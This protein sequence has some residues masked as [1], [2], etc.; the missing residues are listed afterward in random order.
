MDRPR[1]VGGDSSTLE[2]VSRQQDAFDVGNVTG[3]AGLPVG[4]PRRV[5]TRSCRLGD[6]IVVIVAYGSLVGEVTDAALVAVVEVVE[7]IESAI[8]DNGV[9]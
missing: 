2:V 8:G 1:G 3:F 9:A 5:P 6:L 4:A 7:M